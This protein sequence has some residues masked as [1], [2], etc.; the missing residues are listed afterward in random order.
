MIS[1][2]NALQIFWAS[3]PLPFQSVSG[4][5]ELS[6]VAVV[7]EMSGAPA[8]K[9]GCFA[10]ELAL[11]CHELSSMDVAF[12]EIR[13]GLTDKFIDSRGTIV[14]EGHIFFGHIAANFAPYVGVATLRALVNR[15][16][17][18]G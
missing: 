18:E 2:E 16:N 15:V 13:A 6:I 8:K 12:F 4:V 11:K 10:A 14:R 3:R 1:S 17:G 7:A 9:R 5:F